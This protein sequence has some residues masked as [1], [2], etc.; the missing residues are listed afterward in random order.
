MYGMIHCGIRQMVVEE[1]GEEAWVSLERD[2]GSGPQDMIA[3]MVYDDALTIRFLVTASERLGLTLEEG[4][5]SF[6]RYWIR[7]A[8][9]GSFGSILRFTG[10]DIAA[11]IANL[12]RM[13]RAVVAALPEA[14][15]PSFSLV[16]QE[17]G[18]LR[19]QY[20][21]D[22]SGLEPFV[23]GLLQG[24]VDR[25]DLEGE[26]A[27]VPSQSNAVEFEITYVQRG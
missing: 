25:F 8:E 22:R 14:Q 18:L 13:H 12:D 27:R 15:V 20:R 24:I 16:R 1:L 21:S 2:L 19:V 10:S 23:L 17:P 6:G 4:L 3:A 11:F 26:V 5:K 9:R 7:F